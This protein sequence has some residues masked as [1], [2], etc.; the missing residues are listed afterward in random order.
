MGSGIILNAQSV[1]IWHEH[2]PR[3]VCATYPLQRRWYVVTSHARLLS[4]AASV[5]WRHERMTSCHAYIHAKG[6]H[7]STYCDSRVHIQLNLFGFIWLVLSTISQ[8]GGI[9]LDT[10]VFCYFWCFWHGSVAT[11]CMYGG[12]YN[13]HLMANL[14]LSPTVKEFKRSVSICQ[15][16]EWISSCTFLWLTVYSDSAK[17]RQRC[18][19]RLWTFVIVGGKRVYKRL[20]FVQRL[21]TTNIHKSQF[22]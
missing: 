15:S 6:G 12:K 16:Y 4:D 10:L 3:D 9:V 21:L 2:T 14:L 1:L 22:D 7:F 18:N 8:N 17:L 11:R 5:H 13:K 20:S 19:K